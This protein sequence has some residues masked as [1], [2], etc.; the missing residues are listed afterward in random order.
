MKIFI[1]NIDILNNIIYVIFSNT[2]IYFNYSY[3][4]IHNINDWIDIL[5]DVC[6]INCIKTDV[7][8]ILCY[9]NLIKDYKRASIMSLMAH[10]SI[11]MTLFYFGGSKRI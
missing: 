4:P 2:C 1:F 8:I 9:E 5:Q 6:L 10:A 3:F 11:W 7:S